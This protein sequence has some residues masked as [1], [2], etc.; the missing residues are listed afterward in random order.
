[1]T[2]SVQWEEKNKMDVLLRSDVNI[3]VND[4]QMQLVFISFQY[5]SLTS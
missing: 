1:M 3:A 4:P 5:H 2:N